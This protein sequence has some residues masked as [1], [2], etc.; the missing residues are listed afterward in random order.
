MVEI[1]DTLASEFKMLT[2]VLSHRNMSC[3]GFLSAIIKYEN[4]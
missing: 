4:T 1:C 2:L 3:S